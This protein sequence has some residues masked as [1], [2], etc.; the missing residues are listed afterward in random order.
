MH[1][2]KKKKQKQ[3]QNQKQNQNIQKVQRG[4]KLGTVPYILQPM[5]PRYNVKQK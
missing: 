3:K 1:D 5:F 2:K 4:Q